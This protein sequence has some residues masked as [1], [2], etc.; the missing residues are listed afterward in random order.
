LNTLKKL[1]GQTAVYG[2]G[3]ILGRLITFI[4]PIFFS[5]DKYFSEEQLGIYTNLYAYVGFFV[6]FFTY[7]ME[8]TLF[9][10]AGKSDN[11]KGVV[12]TAFLSII[13]STLLFS[14]SL[15]LLAPSIASFL[16]IPGFSNFVIMLAAVLGLDAIC[17]IPF[18]YLRFQNKAEKFASI[19]LI[20]IVANFSLCIYFMGPLIIGTDDVSIYQMF[21]YHYDADFNIGYLLTANLIAS[22]LTLILLLP[23]IVTIPFKFDKAIWQSMIRYASPLL[24]VGFAGVIN[25][26]LDRAIL[27]QLLDGTSEE[28]LA[29]M[30]IYG[31]NYRMAMSMAIAIQAFRMAA[32]PFFFSKAKDKD[33][34]KLFAMIMKYFILFCWLIFLAEALFLNQIKHIP[35]K[36]FEEGYKVI[37]IILLANLFLGIYYNLAVWYKL[38]DKTH[39][40]AIISVIGAIISIVGNFILIPHL[41]YMGSA[42]TTL[43]CYF[44]MVIISYFWGRKHMHIPYNL[45]KILFYS[46]LALSMY[47]ASMIPEPESMTQILV[48]TALFLTYIS[49]ILIIEKPRKLLS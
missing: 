35:G 28:K 11:P 3:N 37:P 41:G 20:N 18:A 25:E 44:S 22:A 26:M 13:G 14:L 29:Q 2:L 23:V 15:I 21:D 31:I 16:E 46:I 5:Q 24:I 12:S 9:R 17:A 27:L 43:I 6:V 36:G 10:F 39:F 49:T 42:W 7:G 4:I 34:P 38:T 33:S 32:E 40:G 48:S 8:T 19:R 45:R 1:L 30:G 47:F